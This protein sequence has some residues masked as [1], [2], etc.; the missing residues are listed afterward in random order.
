M[1]YLHCPFC[2][3]GHDQQRVCGCPESLGQ[4]AARVALASDC[5]TETKG[6][7][8]SLPAGDPRNVG[9]ILAVTS[10]WALVTFPKATP[11]SWARHIGKEAMELKDDPRD[12]MEIADGLILY[13]GLATKCGFDIFEIVR[14]KH[15]IN[16]G[17][18]WGAPDADGVVEHVRQGAEVAP[19]APAGTEEEETAK[20][21]TELERVVCEAA[22]NPSDTRVLEK[23]VL[24]ATMRL[25]DLENI[26]PW[27]E[28]KIQALK[29]KTAAIKA[30]RA[31]RALARG[32]Q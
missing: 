7:E 12:P 30:L 8:P 2:G 5:G 22:E 23:A 6:T 29:D 27:K 31:H 1:S 20:P 17:R 4:E 14:T 19:Q 10:A 16:L 15:A 3:K 32:Q 9:E 13:A 11:E 21:L 25:D 28:V 26:E 24:D 18:T